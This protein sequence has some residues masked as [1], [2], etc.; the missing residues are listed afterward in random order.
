MIDFFTIFLA[1]IVSIIFSV[2]VRAHCANKGIIDNVSE[3]SSHKNP[4]PRGGGLIFVIPTSIFAFIWYAIH[5]HTLEN[6]FTVF[7][8]LVGSMLI[9][10]IGWIEDTKGLSSKTRLLLEAFVVAG[11]AY[12]MPPIFEG[13]LGYW[14][15]KALIFFAWL[16]FINLYNFMDG[17]N[18]F[19]TMQGLFLAFNL[20]F[21]ASDFKPVLLVLLGCLFA[22]LRVNI[23]PAKIFMGDVGS[24]YLGTFLGGLMFLLLSSEVQTWFFPLLT[25][26]L[27]FTFDSTFTLFKRILQGK[28]PWKA[29]KE[30]LYQRANQ[31]GFSHEQVTVRALVLNIILFVIFVVQLVTDLDILLFILALIVMIA[32]VKYIQ[33]MENKK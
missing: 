2:F 23:T 13:T 8:L 10:I 14:G 28:A 7:S 27:L 11:M 31:L 25:L 30:H 12:Y 4:T 20:S 17:L 24:L 21:F 29:H 9:A 5:G 16:W 15:D 22:F 1:V 32:V 6:T 18:G 3:R 26:S 19:A 33:Y